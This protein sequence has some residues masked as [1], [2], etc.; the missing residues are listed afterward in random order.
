[1]RTQSHIKPFLLYANKGAICAPSMQ[2]SQHCDR[3]LYRHLSVN[4]SS[5]FYPSTHLKKNMYKSF[6][7]AILTKSKTFISSHKIKLNRNTLE[8]LE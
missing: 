6:A 7:H 1:M 5:M 2:R 4:I 3:F 8:Q